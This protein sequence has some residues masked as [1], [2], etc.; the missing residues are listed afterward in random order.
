MLNITLC[1]EAD[2]ELVVSI[3]PPGR[4]VLLN[5]NHGAR[6]KLQIIGSVQPSAV[7][8]LTPSLSPRAQWFS[9]AHSNADVKWQSVQRHIVIWAGQTRKVK[10][11]PP[12]RQIEQVLL[13][14]W[15][16]ASK[17]EMTW[18]RNGSG[19]QI[20]GSSNAPTTSRRRWR[21]SRGAE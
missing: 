1:V 7:L 6:T 8:T 12:F 17:E 20:F 5:S 16:A 21:G 4:G 3:N 13:P 11:R 15:S 2:Y 14:N 10:T 18:I 19:T 9:P